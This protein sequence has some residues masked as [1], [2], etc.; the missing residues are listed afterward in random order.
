MVYSI[1]GT[2]YEFIFWRLIMEN[3]SNKTLSLVYCGACVALI[4]ICSWISI[5]MTIP[6]TLQTFAVCLATALLGTKRG[7]VTV[8]VYILLGLVGVP[9]FSGFKG[10]V[11]VLLGP[12]GGYIIGFIFTAIVVGLITDKI[13]K[14]VPVLAL[15]MILGIF[16][17]YL[18][19]TF[20]F[21]NVYTKTKEPVSIATALSWCVFPY[22]IPD[23]CKIALAVFLE[24]RLER[25]I[26]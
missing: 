21:V 4:A 17:C 15:A 1:L 5:P 25:V 20:W 11:S 8:L 14:S 2:T 24:K 6:F 13:N 23:A 26:L 18:F 7:T 19:G 12:T 22:L 9:V 3:I 10:G 16:V